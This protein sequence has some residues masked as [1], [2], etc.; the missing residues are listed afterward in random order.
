MTNIPVKDLMDSAEGAR[1]RTNSSDTRFRKTTST[2]KVTI[3]YN[4]RLVSFRLEASV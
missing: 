2:V 1:T 3:I 4:N